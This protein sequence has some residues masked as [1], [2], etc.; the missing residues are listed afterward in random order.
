MAFGLTPLGLFP[1]R[2][3]DVKADLEDALKEALG[4]N[5]QLDATSVLGQIV[6]VM[7]ERYADLWEE[8][9]AVYAQSYLAGAAGAALDDLLALGAITREPATF[10]EVVLTLTG[11]GGTVVPAGSIVADPVLDV[12]W[13]TLA[14][15]TIGTDNPTARPSATGPVRGLAGTITEIRT[16]V[17]NW[18][19]V[20]NALDATEGRAVQSDASVRAAFRAAMRASG[21]NSVDGIAALLLRID[22]VDEAVV[23]ENALSFTDLD[24]RPPHSFEAV[25]RGGDDQEIADAIWAGK[26]AGI[27][28]YGSELDTVVDVNGDAQ[29]VKWSRPTE[30]DIYMIVEYAVEAGFPE[31]GEDQ[32]L[33]AILDHGTA[34]KIGDDVIPFQFIQKI[35]VENMLDLTIKVGLAPN[36]ATDDPLVVPLTAIADF[37]S[38]RIS[39]VRTN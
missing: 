30:L 10:S 15:A 16:P 37:D 26:P 3:E 8:L 32:M 24:G 25:V 17:A 5:I 21:G 19:G 36:P 9:E 34:F 4:Q 28:T 13:T 18:T 27:E 33:D 6:G 31:D 20:T 39:F 35:D 11:T 14:D 29:L 12:E 2:L 7:S 38:T 23:I 22:D 1:R